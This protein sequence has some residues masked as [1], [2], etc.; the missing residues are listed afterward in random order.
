MP[1]F[2]SRFLLYMKRGG[3]PDEDVFNTPVDST[4]VETPEK[5]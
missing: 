4:L 5:K 3:I 1:G 2:L